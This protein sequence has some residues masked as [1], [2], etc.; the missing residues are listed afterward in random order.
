[1]SPS[2]LRLDLAS[3]QCLSLELQFDL[4][5]PDSVRRELSILGSH[6]AD[7]EELVYFHEDYKFEAQ[8]LHS[9]AEVHLEDSGESDVLIEY[10]TESELEDQTEIHHTDFT[11]AH[12]FEALGPI[13]NKVTA[14]FTIRFDLGHTHSVRFS[15]LLPYELGFNGGHSVEYKGAHMQV[16]NHKGE[17][18]D[19]WFD[20][21]TDDSVEATLRF[22]L[23]ELPSQELPGRGLIYGTEALARLMN[24]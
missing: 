3:A 11:L 12:L 18:F 14:A 15:R 4:A 23:E 19:L 17:L 1:M 21:R 22:S 9:W 7:Q 10:L 20:L 16:K 5:L 2:P 8:K 6:E 24:S 13:T